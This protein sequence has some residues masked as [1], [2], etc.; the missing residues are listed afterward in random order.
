MEDTFKQ[1]LLTATWETYSK[2]NLLEL[3]ASFIL[4]RS[5]SPF[6]LSMFFFLRETPEEEPPT[7]PRTPTGAP[8]TH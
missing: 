8:R 4:P 6:E 5:G 1:G 3:E 2:G 7:P